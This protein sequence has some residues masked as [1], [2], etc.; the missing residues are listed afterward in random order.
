VSRSTFLDFEAAT[1]FDKYSPILH[2][3]SAISALVEV[4]LYQKKYYAKSTPI[5]NLEK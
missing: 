5:P 3:Q 4:L 2:S 1:Y